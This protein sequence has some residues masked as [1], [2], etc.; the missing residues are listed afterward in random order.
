MGAPVHETH[1]RRMIEGNRFRVGNCAWVPAKARLV[2]SLLSIDFEGH[3]GRRVTVELP[4]S[5]DLA[6]VNHRAWL[7]SAVEHLLAESTN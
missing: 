5:F 1:L 2:G 3:S 4:R 7:W 6:D